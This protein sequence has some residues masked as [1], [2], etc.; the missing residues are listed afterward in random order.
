[1]CVLGLGSE[2]IVL[3]TLEPRFETIFASRN[4]P[5]SSE[6]SYRLQELEKK[7]DHLGLTSWRNSSVQQQISGCGQDIPASA[8]GQLLWSHYWCLFLIHACEKRSK[9]PWET[10]EPCA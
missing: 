4:F 10:A 5:E 1:M 3:V 2:P 6:G 7:H 8:D 9:D